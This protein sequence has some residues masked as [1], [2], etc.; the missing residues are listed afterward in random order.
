MADTKAV[1]D[2]VHEKGSQVVVVH[3]ATKYLNA[4]KLCTLAVS[5]GETATLVKHPASMT[6]AVIPRE[7]RLKYGIPDEL[8][9][10][11]VGLE[12]VEDIIADVKQAL[13]YIYKGS[14]ISFFLAMGRVKQRSSNLQPNKKERLLAPTLPRTVHWS[15]VKTTIP[16]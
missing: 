14:D 15:S 4:L 11:S 3:S 6:H 5:L 8:V 10:M 12:N 7:N 16:P 2:I 1:S 9:R 13:E